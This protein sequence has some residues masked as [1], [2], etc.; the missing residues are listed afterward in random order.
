MPRRTCRC[1]LAHPPD[2]RALQALDLLFAREHGVSVFVLADA[3]VELS[4]DARQLG[5][6]EL[7]ERAQE[8][9]ITFVQAH[10]ALDLLESRLLGIGKRGV[11]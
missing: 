7:P 2:Q 5:R 11:F 6:S 10:V 9:G 3:I 4:R 1:T 8:L